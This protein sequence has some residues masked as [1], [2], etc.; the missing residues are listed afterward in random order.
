M[1]VWFNLGFHSLGLMDSLQ[2]IAVSS[3]GCVAL[4]ESSILFLAA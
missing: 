4:G 3:D 2:S 1:S